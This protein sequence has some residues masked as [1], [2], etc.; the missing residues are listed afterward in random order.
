MASS[1]RLPDAPFTVKVVGVTFVPG[2]PDNLLKLEEMCRGLDLAS[3]SLPVV[4]VRNPL[5][6]H[7]PNAIEVHMP[8]MDQIG[9]IGHLP[10]EMAA[11]LAPELDAGVHWLAELFQVLINFS[12]MDR[13]GISVR[14][15]RVVDDG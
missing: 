1:K 15:Q 5:N 8:A 12:H 10:A 7:D 13:P 3:E 9:M 4:L 6:E 2:Y 14:L 11:R